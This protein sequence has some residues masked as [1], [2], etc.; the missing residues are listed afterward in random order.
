[1]A[2]FRNLASTIPAF[3]TAEFSRGGEDVSPTFNPPTWKARVFLYIRHLGISLKTCPAWV[4]LPS[5]RLRQHSFLRSLVH[6]SSFTQLNIPSSGWRY[7]PE[8]QFSYTNLL[9]PLSRVLLEKLI[10]SQSR[11]STH[12]MS[13]PHSQV[14]A[15]CPYPEPAR[16]SPCPPS[17]FL[18]INLNIILP[19]MPGTSK[20]SLSFRFPYQNPVYTST[21]PIR[22]TCP[23]HLIL[24][25][26][27]T[28]TILGDE[29]RSLSS[30]LCSCLHFPITSSILG[31]NILL[32]I[33]FSNA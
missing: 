10:G 30:S 21:L 20:W 14:P 3:E 26:M 28:R 27:I 12:F 13:L 4:A 8:S 19:F 31:P 18:K 5:T 9:T 33:L 24:L 29:Y 15:T 23:G 25:D 16:S 2:R 17:H 11:N 22:A 6:S 1:V 7:Y 32:S